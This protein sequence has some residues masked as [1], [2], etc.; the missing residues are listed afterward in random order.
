MLSFLLISESCCLKIE[1]NEAIPNSEA[2][3]NVER[4][5][6]KGA[7]DTMSLILIMRTANSAEDVKVEVDL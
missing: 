1:S 6:E 4:Y 5:F 3:T 2:V 7:T